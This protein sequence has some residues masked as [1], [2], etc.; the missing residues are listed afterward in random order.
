M[1]KFLFASLAAAFAMATVSSPAVAQLSEYED[2]E[3]SDTVVEMTTIRVDPGQLDTYLEGLRQTW[4]ASNEVAKGLGYVT[5][6]GIYSNMAPSSGDFHLLLVI[7]FPGQNLQ[8]SRERYDAFMEAWGEANM[9]NS[10]ETVVN[11]YNEIRE[12]QGV[13]LTREIKMMMD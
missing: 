5:D 12:I 1:S 3:Y 9:D 11:I 2:Y 8:P 7:E 13:Y 4:V 6:Y 10:N